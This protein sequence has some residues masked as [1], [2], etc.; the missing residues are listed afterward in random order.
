MPSLSSTSIHRCE[1]E[2]GRLKIAWL[3]KLTKEETETKRDTERRA[4]NQRPK[5]LNGGGTNLSSLRNFPDNS[6]L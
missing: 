3:A 2:L 6:N 4:F 5:A 1:L